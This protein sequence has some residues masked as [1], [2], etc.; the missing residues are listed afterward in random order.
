MRRSVM[1]YYA[2]GMRDLLQTHQ[3]SVE[4]Y[5]ELDEFQIQFIEMCFKQSLDEKMGLMSEVEAYNLEIFNDF[6]NIQFQERYGLIDE[7]WKKAA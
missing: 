5:S 7:L 6:K 3:L 1:K 4:F 2:H